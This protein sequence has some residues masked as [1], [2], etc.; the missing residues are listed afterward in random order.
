MLAQDQRTSLYFFS[1]DTHYPL[2]AMRRRSIMMNTM[3]RMAQNTRGKVGGCRLF[4]CT[5]EPYITFIPCSSRG[6]LNP[7]LEEHF[8]LL[9]PCHRLLQIRA[10]ARRRHI[11][12]AIPRT[13]QYPQRSL[14]E[15]KRETRIRCY[16]RKRTTA[17]AGECAKAEG[18]SVSI[19]AVGVIHLKAS[20]IGN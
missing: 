13:V 9:C 10:C 18:A 19:P 7:L 12:D 14:G 5:L 20:M 3:I 2:S 15:N 8:R 4:F 16:N 17:F 6:I 11:P 1:I